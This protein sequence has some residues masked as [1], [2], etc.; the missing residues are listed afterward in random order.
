MKDNFLVKSQTALTCTTIDK[1]LVEG[2]NAERIVED[3]MKYFE[4]DTLW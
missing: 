2:R 4:T 1:H 3:I